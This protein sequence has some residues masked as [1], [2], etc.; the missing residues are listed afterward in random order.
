MDRGESRVSTCNYTST[1]VDHCLISYLLFIL[2][3][4]NL[5]DAKATAAVSAI[6]VPQ[7][8][9]YTPVPPSIQTVVNPQSLGFFS[10]EEVADSLALQAEDGTFFEEE[11]VDASD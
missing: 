5:R 4:Q 11:V 3:T 1:F 9:P 10:E 7:V 6:S 2:L 8:A